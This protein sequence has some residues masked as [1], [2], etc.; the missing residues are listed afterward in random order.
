MCQL[1]TEKNYT[2]GLLNLV[3]GQYISSGI[4][5]KHRGEQNPFYT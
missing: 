3:I 2:K 1:L 4:F 5:S